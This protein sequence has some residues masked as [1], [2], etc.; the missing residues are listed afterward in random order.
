MK[1]LAS[2]SAFAVA[3]ALTAGAASAQA[4]PQDDEAKP[5]LRREPAT[6]RVTNNNWLDARVYVDDDGVLLPVGFIM[7]QQTKQ[8][9]L[10]TRVLATAGQVRLVVRPIG[11]RQ[12][13]VSQNLL[14][15]AGDALLVELQNQLG[16]SSTS[17]LPALD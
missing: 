16:L 14:V 4:P 1:K 17:V 12:V 7:S 8:F 9:T 13:Y 2:L 10:P 5:V 6:V 3:F 11:S 15:G